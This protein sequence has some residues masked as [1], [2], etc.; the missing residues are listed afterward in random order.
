MKMSG[1]TYQGPQERD[2]ELLAR[3]PGPLRSLLSQVNGFILMGGALH[4]RGA[5]KLPAW[6]S[7]EE[8][9]IGE[10]CLSTCYE[11]VEPEDVPFAEDALGDQFLLREGVV[12]RLHAETGAIEY[13][14][15]SLFEFLEAVQEDPVT[16]LQLEPFLSFYRDG[17]RLQPGEL[18]MAYP[19]FCTRESEAGVSFKAVPADQRLGFL[20]DFSA[21]VSKLPEGARISIQVVR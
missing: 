11:A 6:H 4:V 18:L 19:P 15:K 16:A 12:S 21:K 2:D 10:R 1:I 14:G 9:W 20:A 3:L 17:G 13:L 7:L 5:C 8:A